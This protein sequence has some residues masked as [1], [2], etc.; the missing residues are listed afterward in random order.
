MSHAV[1]AALSWATFS[2]VSGRIGR[3]MPCWLHAL[4]CSAVRCTRWRRAPPV[5]PGVVGRAG[6]CG[7]R[8][9][10]GAE[11]DGAEAGAEHPPEGRGALHGDSLGEGDTGIV[12]P[13]LGPA[14]GKCQVLREARGVP[15]DHAISP[16]RAVARS[17]VAR[18][19]PVVVV[20]GAPVPRAIL[21]LA[22]E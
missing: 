5:A 9:D 6:R 7:H 19:A 2:A 18:R 4:R 12:A 20:G 1:A 21:S 22:I 11:H 13:V 3:V 10:G 15:I 16:V 8:D 14:S 17:A